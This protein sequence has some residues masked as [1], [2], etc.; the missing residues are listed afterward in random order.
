MKKLLDMNLSEG[1]DKLT[2]ADTIYHLPIWISK[3]II[4]KALKLITANLLSA[5]VTT[6]LK[7]ADLT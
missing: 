3:V 4:L 1:E 2:T 5:F 7:S 6:M